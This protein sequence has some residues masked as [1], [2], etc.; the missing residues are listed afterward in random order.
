MATE[1]TGKN[2]NQSSLDNEDWF[3]IKVLVDLQNFA[4]TKTK[5]ITE[6]SYAG[7]M[8]KV[9]HHLGLPTHHQLHFGRFMGPLEMELLDEADNENIRI[10]GNWDPK[11]QEKAYSS[12]LPMKA[13]K[14]KAGYGQNGVYYC[15]RTV[16][17]PF[18]ELYNLFWSF[19]EQQLERVAATLSTNQP[20][21]RRTVSFCFWK[22]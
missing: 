19:V 18:L 21:R 14:S 15:E 22:A 17:E 13:M 3:D 10:L 1:R 11:Q 5:G 2:E 16:M 7:E 8:L 9:L 20:K 12:K 6:K 4:E